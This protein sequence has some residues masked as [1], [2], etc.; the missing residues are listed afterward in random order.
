MQSEC[1]A[2]GTVASKATASLLA[3]LQAK[4]LHR[5]G[6]LL[7]AKGLHRCWHGCKPSDCIAVGII[8]IISSSSLLPLFYCPAL[9]LPL[10]SQSSLLLPLPLGFG[11]Q[12]ALD[13][14]LLEPLPYEEDAAYFGLAAFWA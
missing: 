11:I 3:L 14:L 2:V 9:A 4:R 1:I 12:A 7:Q 13:E 8:A 5:C 6:G 10:A